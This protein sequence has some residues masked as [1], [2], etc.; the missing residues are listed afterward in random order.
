MP[1]T[2][3]RSVERP[4]KL[5]SL[6]WTTTNTSWQTSSMSR[7]GTPR[8]RR[9]LQTNAEYS[10]K[11]ARKDGT[12]GPESGALFD[13]WVTANNL[14]LK[15]GRHT[16]LSGDQHGGHL[17]KA[18]FVPSLAA[19]AEGF[20]Q[21]GRLSVDTHPNGQRPDNLQSSRKSEAQI[22]VR[23]LLFFIGVET[24]ALHVERTHVLDQAALECNGRLR[25]LERAHEH[26]DLL[27]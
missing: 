7:S 21:Q 9:V 1:Y 17:E 16:Y 10:S 14:L 5:S 26:P 8:C 4:S 22:H 23:T 13:E 6:R 12:S 3:V 24:V 18:G 27:R 19:V 15:V 25:Y 2:H 20:T 11:I